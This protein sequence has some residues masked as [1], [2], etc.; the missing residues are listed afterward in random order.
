MARTGTRPVEAVG[1]RNGII[2]A[3]A[4]WMAARQAAQRKESAAAGAVS[5]N[6]FR[7]VFRAC[8]QKPAGGWQQWRY[9]QLISVQHGA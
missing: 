4:P 8:W 5:F 6:R 3:S 7:G 2:A 1:C 9:K